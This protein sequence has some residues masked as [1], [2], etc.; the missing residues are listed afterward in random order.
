VKCCDIKAADLRH[1]VSL[2][3]KQNNSDGVGGSTIT[4]VEYA[5]PW[6]KI[7][8]KTGGEKLYLGRL[9]AQG[10]SSVVM[11]YRADIVASDKLVFKGQD[12]QIRSII[13]VEERNKYTELL[14]ERGVTQ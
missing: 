1:R 10:L 9:D 7:T 3:R 13:N 2:Q 12:F 4:W 11:R 5:T 8:P 6:C 14:I